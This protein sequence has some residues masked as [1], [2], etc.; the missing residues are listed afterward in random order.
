MGDLPNLIVDATGRGTMNF[1]LSAPVETLFDADGT[2]L[3]V[4]A[5]ADDERTDPSGNSGARIACA[6]LN[7]A[8]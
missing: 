7:R 4:H 3:V 1:E 8:G 2:A 5:G 6:V